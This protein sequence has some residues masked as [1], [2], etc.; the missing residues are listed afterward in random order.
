MSKDTKYLNFPICLLAGF[1]DEPKEKL[2]DI[3]NFSIAEKTMELQEG[4]LKERLKATEKYFQVNCGNAD[5]A[6]KQGSILVNSIDKKS[7]RAGLSI[8]IFFNYYKKVNDLIEFDAACFLAFL[9]I[10]SILGKKPYCKTNK[11][12]IVARMFG[13]T[14]TKNIKDVTKEHPLMQKYSTRY[15]LEKIINEL[16]FSWNLKTFA[17]HS[18]GRW[19][20]FDLDYGFLAEKCLTAKIDFKK[21]ELAETKRKALLTAETKVKRLK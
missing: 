14:S 13:Y 21:K 20:S 8:E 17:N 10:R 7:P 12:L 9:A 4:N 3:F 19:V 6:F 2:D 16:E 18:R 11:G 5:L 1:F 15:H